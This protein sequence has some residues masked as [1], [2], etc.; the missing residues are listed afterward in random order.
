MTLPPSLRI[1]VVEDNLVNQK[2]ASGLLRREGHEVVVAANGREALRTLQ[3]QLF[4]LVLMDV[5]MPEMDGLQT[6]A[7]IRAREEG[8]GRRVPIIALTAQALHGDRERCLAAGMDAYL[9]KPVHAQQL[10]Q[11]VSTV[12][13]RTE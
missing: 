7:A 13:G 10:L 6:T 5:Q 4:D 8:T 2:V 1:L 11:T 12:A 3:A 9:S